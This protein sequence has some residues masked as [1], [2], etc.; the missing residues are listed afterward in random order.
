MTVKQLVEQTSH[1]FEAAGISSSRLDAE[2][3]ISFG[4]GHDRGWLIAHSDGSLTD[5][6]IAKIKRLTD[7][8]LKRVPVAFITRRKEFYGLN[9]YVDQRVLIPRPETEA[10]V[11]QA[12]HHAPKNSKLLDLGTGCGAIAVAVAH[13]RPDLKITATDVS[14]DAIVV[15]KKNA[16]ILNTKNIQFKTSNLFEHVKD[17]FE[18]VVTNLPYVSSDYKSR[19]TAEAKQEPPVALYGGNDDGLTLYRK[20][21]AQLP[22]HLVK[23]GYLFLESDPWQQP[24]IKQLA[25]AAGLTRIYEHYLV[26]G[27][28]LK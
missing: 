5:K 3:V 16:K 8:R 28:R 11:E 4:L 23:P 7:Q 12:V 21:F 18:T 10:I 6:E 26:T 20:F 1:D 14:K 9:F 13:H 27:Y 22:K 19:L 2:I 15:A 25:D 17:R 24:M